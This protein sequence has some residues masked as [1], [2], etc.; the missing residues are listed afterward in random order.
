MNHVA[1]QLVQEHDKWS[2][3]FMKTKQNQVLHAVVGSHDLCVSGGSYWAF[4]VCCR[5]SCQPQ[6]VLTSIVSTND[7]TIVFQPIYDDSIIVKPT[8]IH[9]AITYHL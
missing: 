8:Y 2:N 3:D 4:H 9:I 5:A 1:Q 7:L 6:S